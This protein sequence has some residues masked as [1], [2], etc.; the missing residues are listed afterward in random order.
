MDITVIGAGEVGFHLAD[1]LSREDHRVSVIDT[2]PV[3][4]RRI[5]ESLDVQVVL[6]DGTDADVLNRGGVSRADLL[7]VVT[8]DDDELLAFPRN[9]YA[10]V[11]EFD[12]L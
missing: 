12:L 10:E 1:I 5:M 9:P 3:K 11:G 4:S 8:A 2:D 6:G 7:V